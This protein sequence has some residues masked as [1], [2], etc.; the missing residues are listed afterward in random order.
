MIGRIVLFFSSLCLIAAGCSTSVGNTPQ[1]EPRQ[2]AFDINEIAFFKEEGHNMIKGR[3]YA[4]KEDG[5]AVTCAGEWVVLHP[6]STYAR[7]YFFGGARPSSLQGN[8]LRSVGDRHHRTIKKTKMDLM[9]Q[10]DDYFL[11][12]TN[13]MNAR[14]NRRGEFWFRNVPDGPYYILATVEWQEG[15]IWY[16]GPFVKP[17]EVSGGKVKEVT[18]SP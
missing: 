8:M 4:V 5:E 10:D 14:C 17:V 1:T 9:M 7:N 11:F 2:G 12:L 16:G 15:N 13:Q 6:Q 3:A 18:I